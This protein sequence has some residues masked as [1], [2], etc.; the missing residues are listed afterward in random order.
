MK[1][2]ENTSPILLKRIDELTR[3]SYPYLLPED[4]V[5]YL[6]EYTVRE[7]A[8]FSEMNRLIFNYKKKPEC[9]GKADWK[10]KKEAIEK[11]AQYSQ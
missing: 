11:I 3:T 4:E 10:Y 9:E 1:K 5:Y 7:M 2:S 6:G 8:V